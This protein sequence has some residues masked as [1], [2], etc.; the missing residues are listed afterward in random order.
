MRRRY[1]RAAMNQPFGDRLSA[2]IRKFDAAV[3]VG[4]DPVIDK[5]PAD[6][7]ERAARKPDEALLAYGRG[8]IE[9][10]AGKVPAIKINIAFF[11]PFFEAGLS[12]Y[13]ELTRAAHRAGLIVIGDIKRAD[14]GHSSQQYATA[15]VGA[16]HEDFVDA[17]TVNPYF[18]SDGID[19]FLETAAKNSRG[20]FVLV[21]T[22]NAS[23]SQVQGLTLPDGQTVCQK[24]AQLVESWAGRSAGSSGY[25][26][27]GAVVS[28]RDLPSTVLIR[29]LMPSCIFLVPGFGAQGRTTDEVSKCFKEDGSGAIVTASRSVIYAYAEPKY[30]GQDWQSAVA[31]S[32]LDF[33]QEIRGLTRA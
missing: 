15:H 13:R 31:A 21:Q 7:R 26:P 2:A 8:V 20:V 33:A 10:I 29:K 11:E 24:V 25:S 6:L 9:A 4:L 1:I 23:A 18:G 22:S 28:P 16:D 12:A 27:V 17:V 19:P 5:L 32:C 3:C 14:I 30:A